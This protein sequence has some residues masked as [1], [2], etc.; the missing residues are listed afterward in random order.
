VLETYT[1]RVARQVIAPQTAREVTRALQQ[2]M[3]D[4]TGKDIKVP[5]FEGEVAGK[6]G[7]AQK[8]VNGQYSHT[9][10]VAS[11]IGFLPADDPAFVAL[12]MVD[13]PQTKKYYGAEVS[14][15]VFADL[16]TQVAQIMNLTPEQPIAPMPTLT[17]NAKPE[18]ESP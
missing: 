9:H 4:G 16:A 6:T 10:H 11:F 18:S 1:P 7:T 12:V 14:A 3:V 8:I 17:S 13:D 5:G 2:V 15:P